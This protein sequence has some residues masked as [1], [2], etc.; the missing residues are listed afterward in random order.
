MS[1][2]WM[3]AQFPSMLGRVITPVALL[4]FWAASGRKM[5]QPA[6][7]RSIGK[8]GRTD[9]RVTGRGANRDAMK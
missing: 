1:K 2:T 9:G 7:A 6:S 4:W 8:S 3:S 5:S